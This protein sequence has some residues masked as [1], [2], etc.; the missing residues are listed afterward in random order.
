MNFFRFNIDDLQG[1]TDE[2]IPGHK[3]ALGPARSL[4]GDAVQHER[5]TIRDVTLWRFKEFALPR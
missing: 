4:A 2:K 1:G 5:G 3:P